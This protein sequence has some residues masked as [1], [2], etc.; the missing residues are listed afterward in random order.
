[1]KT[2]SGVTDQNGDATFTVTDT[3]AE[4]VTYT[5]TDST[6]SL[7]ITGQSATVAFTTAA[8]GSTTTTTTAAAGSTTTT[9]SGSS[10]TPS[11]GSSDQASTAADAG[12]VSAPSGQLALTGAPSLLPWLFALGLLLLLG[13]SFGRRLAR[14][15]R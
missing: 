6:D 2:V 11:G 5:A 8:A 12:T 15:G 4:S 14:V 13:G 7:P 9:A 3:T 1:M 10:T